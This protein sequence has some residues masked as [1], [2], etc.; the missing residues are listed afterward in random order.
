MFCSNCGKQLDD[1]A[2]Y[3]THCGAKVIH[4]GE[5]ASSFQSQ[6]SVFKRDENSS[7]NRLPQDVHN[8]L[9]SEV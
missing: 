3:C 5:N 1:N 4:I 6:Q 7:Y 8:R 9:S 2:K